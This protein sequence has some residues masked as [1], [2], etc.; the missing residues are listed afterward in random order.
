MI[1][2]S[3]QYDKDMA[4]AL[5]EIAE[6]RKPEARKRIIYQI[7]LC[8]C[9]AILYYLAIA[10]INAEGVSAS[11][12]VYIIIA[13]VALLF[14]IFQKR[15]RV[16]MILRGMLREGGSILTAHG[17]WTFSDESIETDSTLGNGVTYWTAIEKYGDHGKYIYIQRSDGA[18]FLLE[19]TR[20][21]EA[22]I[23]ELQNLL[24]KHSIPKD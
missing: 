11:S 16:S 9:A 15:M 18:V 1:T 14:A 7:I 6:Q 17:T 3:F 22:E 24:A 5:A 8:V 4:K 19:R 10:L 23:S 20:L 21:S 12:I 2:Y 13:T